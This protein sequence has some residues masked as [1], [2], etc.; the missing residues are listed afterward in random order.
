MSASAALSRL[1]LYQCFSLPLPL[2]LFA[3]THTHTQFTNGQNKLSRQFF[4]I[5]NS[6]LPNIIYMHS[7]VLWDVGVTE[8]GWPMIFQDEWLIHQ[9]F[10]ACSV[11]YLFIFCLILPS[12]RD[13]ICKGVEFHCCKALSFHGI[14]MYSSHWDQRCAVSTYVEWDSHYS[15]KRL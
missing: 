4:L 15:P 2:S 9:I 8:V 14:L 6:F 5:T 13:Q 10:W 7:E 12:W 3:R 11:S 1:S